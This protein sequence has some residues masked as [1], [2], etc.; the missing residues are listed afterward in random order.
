MG[1]RPKET[2]TKASVMSQRQRYCGRG[3]SDRNIST[4]SARVAPWCGRLGLT[5]PMAIF[6]AHTA[7]L[8]P[9][10]RT[11]AGS[12]AS[13]RYASIAR[14]TTSVRGPPASAAPRTRTRRSIP[15][16]PT[17]AGASRPP[18]TVP[19]P[20]PASA[21]ERPSP[22]D[23]CARALRSNRPGP[24]CSTRRT[25]LPRGSSGRRVP[26]NRPSNQASLSSAPAAATLPAKKEGIGPREVLG[27]VTMQ[28]FVRGH[29]TMIAAPVQ[30]DVDGIPKG[31]HW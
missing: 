30:C 10:S 18:R 13:S 21:A 1:K 16:P 11:P 20:T 24:G 3:G 23:P 27:R 17:P 7:S 6:S 2:G 25:S 31:S 8:P 5:I 28:V 26:S 15:T 29:C 12:R 9:P 19:Y 22:D 14:R 4:G